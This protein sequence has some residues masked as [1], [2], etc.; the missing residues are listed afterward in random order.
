M[1]NVMSYLYMKF[2]DLARPILEEFLNNSKKCHVE[3]I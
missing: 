3:E 1:E 2:I